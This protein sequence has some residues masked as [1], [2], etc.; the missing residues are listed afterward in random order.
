[1]DNKLILT[2]I[3]RDGWKFEGQQRVFCT[4]GGINV[5]V[6]VAKLLLASN[7]ELGISSNPQCLLVTS[8]ESF[9][10][11]DFAEFARGIFKFEVITINGQRKKPKWAHNQIPGDL[12]VE[13]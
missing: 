11:E 4:I 6:A 10:F 2:M 9:T 8:G 1:M 12:N 5:S 13:E 7:S 3:C